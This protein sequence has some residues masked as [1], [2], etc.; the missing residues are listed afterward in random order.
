M[1]E[2]TKPNYEQLIANIGTVLAEGRNRVA[3]AINTALVQTYWTIGQHIVEYE[4]QGNERAEYGSNLLNRLVKDLKEQYGVGFNRSNLQ[5]MRKLYVAFPNC[6]TP[7]CKLSW[8][9]YVEII[10]GDAPLETG[11]CVIFIK[12]CLCILFPKCTINAAFR[13]QNSILYFLGQLIY[14][15]LYQCIISA[16]SDVVQDIY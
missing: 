8:R 13:K 6:T 15:S 5:Y 9:H 7:S 14:V 10:K 4:Q 12:S 16:S 1:S 2:I 3:T 11:F